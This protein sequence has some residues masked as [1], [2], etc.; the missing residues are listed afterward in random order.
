MR[1]LGIQ[2]DSIFIEYIPS[3]FTQLNLQMI[4]PLVDNEN[5]ILFLK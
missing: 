1:G 2:N 3:G 5:I 4:I